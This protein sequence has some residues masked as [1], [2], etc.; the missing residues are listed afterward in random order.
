MDRTEHGERG[1][2]VLTTLL[3]A[4]EDLS[5][6]KVGGPGKEY[7]V[8][9]KNYANAPDPAR[10]E[11]SS[12]ETAAWRIEV[13]PKK[14]AEENLLLNVIQV[15]D[16]QA[17]AAMSVARVDAGDRVGCR[18][19]GP[20]GGWVVLFR[21]DGRRTP[22]A[23]SFTLDGKGPLRVLVTDIAPGSWRAR[24][25]GGEAKAVAVTE[26]QGAAWFEAAPGAWT[27][28]RE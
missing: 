22:E 11:K 15:T 16:R 27:L 8:F 10:V 21:K 17:A 2:L 9:G 25:A 13:S 6:E 18:I 24:R 26:E 23:A 1:R 4:A 19:D 7:W 5:L 14:P 12:I 28:T 20:G 3:P